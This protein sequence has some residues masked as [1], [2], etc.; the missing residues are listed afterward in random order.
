MIPFDE[1]LAP[2]Y[3]DVVRYCRALCARWSPDE[4]DDVL[5]QA[6]L[7]ALAGYAAL[8]DP[9]RFR[10]WLFRIV[11][12]S[13]HA[14]AR[15]SAWRRLV[16][17][18]RALVAP[19]AMPAVYRGREPSAATA[20]LLLALGALSPKER[21]AILLFEIAG[22]SLEE[23]RDAQGDRGLSAVKSRLSRARARLRVALEH[24]RSARPSAGGSAMARD[25]EEATLAVL[26]DLEREER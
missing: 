8:R 22:L 18:D 16:P 10:P 25:V 26:R 15:R 2:H 20:E 11:T 23:I 19:D 3:G 9:A 24:P 1:A 4:A 6:L 12:R 7:R 21:A 17:L 13:F 5:Q 14:A